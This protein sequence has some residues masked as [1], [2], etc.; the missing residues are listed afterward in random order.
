MPQAFADAVND[1]FETRKAAW[2]ILGDPQHGQASLESLAR[3][4]KAGALNPTKLQ[5]STVLVEGAKEGQELMAGGAFAAAVKDLRDAK[6][7]VVGCETDKT[8]QGSVITEAAMN[9]ANEA[10]TEI[11]AR[12][13]DQRIVLA[14]KEWEAHAQ[15][16]KKNVIL[17]CG[18]SH[19]PYFHKESEFGLVRRLSFKGMCIGYAVTAANAPDD[20]YVAEWNGTSEKKFTE[21]TVIDPYP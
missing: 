8:L 10:V 17:C 1:A 16:V 4:V 2:L 14:N 6:I 21:I 7:I 12:A 19:L 13:L 15:R 9:T 5:I 11:S 3:A 20:K 18:A